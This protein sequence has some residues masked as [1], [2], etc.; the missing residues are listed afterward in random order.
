MLEILAKLH[1]RAIKIAHML[2]HKTVNVQIPNSG[3]EKRPI[4]LPGD[5]VA[6]VYPNTE[7][8]A[9]LSAF[10]G[11]ILAGMVPVPVEVPITRRDAGIQQFGFLLGSCGARIALT[12]ESC[13]KGLPKAGSQTPTS[14]SS[15][16]TNSPSNPGTYHH[17]T[18]GSTGSGEPSHLPPSS[19]PHGPNDVADFKGW[20]RLQWVVTEHLSKPNKDWKPPPAVTNG[21]IAYVEYVTDREGSVKGVCVTREAML[22]H[23]RAIVA[24]MG[25]KENECMVTV[26]DFKRD[27]G[28]WHAILAGIYAGM[29]VIFV[30][31]SV[32]KVNPTSW[33][34]HASKLQATAAL[35]KSRDLHWSVMATPR[36]PTGQLLP[37]NNAA[38]MSLSTLR[39]VVVADGEY[40]VVSITEIESVF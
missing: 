20:P 15:N 8:V 10:Y 33:M 34:F 24:A 29:R 35:V 26:L 1:T 18:N 39:C 9:F 13:L 4:C 31:Y 30:P 21:E 28:L 5:R 25:Y 32:M 3:K 36:D 2:L 12:S 7:P 14:S 27:V 16:S 22:A 11:C 6:L 23:C 19:G 37:P 38:P 17:S 40:K